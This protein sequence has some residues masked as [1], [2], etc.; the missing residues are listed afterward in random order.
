MIFDKYIKLRRLRRDADNLEEACWSG[1]A[2]DDL[3]ECIGTRPEDED[4]ALIAWLSRGRHVATAHLALTLGESGV[5]LIG[6]ERQAPLP[7]V[8]TAE[9]LA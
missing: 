8:R 6:A 7:V 4:N 2:L 9:L 3:Y 5:N 1:G